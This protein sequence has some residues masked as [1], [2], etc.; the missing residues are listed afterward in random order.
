MCSIVFL[1][2]TSNLPIQ[3]LFSVLP[4]HSVFWC[5][6]F[7]KNEHNPGKS[8]GSDICDGFTSSKCLAFGICANEKVKSYENIIKTRI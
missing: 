4:T 1:A 3:T 8:D 2:F 6:N 7:S 5:T